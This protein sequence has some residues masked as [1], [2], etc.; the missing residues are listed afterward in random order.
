MTN[1]STAYSAVSFVIL[2]YNKEDHLER[3]I[4]SVLAQ[5]GDFERQIICVNNGS[6]D[7]SPQIMADLLAGVE[8]SKIIVHEKNFGVS[9]ALNSGVKAADYAIIK[10]L[11]GDDTLARDGTARL[12]AGLETPGVSLVIGRGK[13]IEH[14]GEI[15]IPRHSDKPE[16]LILKDPLEYCVRHS[17]AGCSD[18][19]FLR[20]AF[21]TAGGCDE[22]VFI[23]DQSYIWRMALHHSFALTEE[24]VYLEPPERGANTLVTNRPQVEHDRAANLYGL[25][26]DHPEL[27][28]RLKRFML[29]RA[30]SRAW[31]WARRVNGKIWGGDPV[32]W[33]YLLSRLPGDRNYLDLLK[34]CLRPYRENTTLFLPKINNPGQGDIFPIQRRDA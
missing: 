23:Q 24:A 21:V 14:E 27:P 7:R 8:N 4:G 22:T 12:M 1:P 3:S 18:S 28:N 34:K 31:K 13:F 15:I 2:C 29:M 9:R 20:D 10:P 5:E 16:Y 30:S 17:L 25:V 19:L 33:I 32:Y 26:R 6:T 11:D